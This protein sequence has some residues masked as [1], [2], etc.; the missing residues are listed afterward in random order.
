MAQESQVLVST[1]PSKTNRL[2][3][4]V[5]GLFAGGPTKRSYNPGYFNVHPNATFVVNCIKDGGAAGDGT[6]SCSWT[7]T[8]ESL[9]GKE[10][11]TSM[12][13]D[14]SRMSNVEYEVPNALGV[15]GLAYIDATGSI[16]LYCANE[17]PVTEEC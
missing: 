9:G 16:R 17:V 10:L 11:G 4:L 12:S 1:N 14:K 2:K 3:D 7:Y 6:S 15:R 13:P 5:G 8:V